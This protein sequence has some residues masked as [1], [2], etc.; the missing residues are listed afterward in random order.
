MPFHGLGRVTTPAR[1]PKG[2]LQGW[3]VSDMLQRFQQT[4]PLTR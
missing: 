4:L 3:G 1:Y 2:R